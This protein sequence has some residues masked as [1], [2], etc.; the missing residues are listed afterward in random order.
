MKI[1]FFRRDNVSNNIVVEDVD[2]ADFSYI[3]E[4]WHNSNNWELSFENSINASSLDHARFIYKKFTIT[5]DSH[6]IYTVY[7]DVNLALKDVS[8]F[9]FNKQ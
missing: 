7:V 3:I 9:L 1:K 2:V 6:Y 5:L 4:L 8:D